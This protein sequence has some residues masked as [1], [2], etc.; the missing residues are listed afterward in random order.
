MIELCRYHKGRF[1]CFIIANCNCLDLLNDP[2][3]KRC[4]CAP[5]NGILNE[6]HALG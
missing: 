1:V 5:I 4:F 6:E 3:D 2:I